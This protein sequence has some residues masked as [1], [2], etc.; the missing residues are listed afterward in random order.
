M[1]G[2]PVVGLDA[3]GLEY[4]VGEEQ[5]GRF[6]VHHEGGVL[7]QRRH[8]ARQ[9]H[10]HLVGENLLSFVV[11]H[12]ATVAVAVETERH[13]GL[14]RQHRVAHGVQHLHVFG[15][16]I[17]A[18]EAVVELA[19]ER[20]H[21]AADRL[22]NARRKSAGGAVAAGGDHFQLALDLRPLGE[23]GDVAVG[24]ILDENV[25]AAAREIELGAEHD[26]LQP[27]H[28]VGPEGERPVGAHLHAG[29]TVVVMR[30]GDHGDAGH[31]QLELR[32]IGH[33]RDRQPDVVHL[34]ARRQQAGDQRQFHRGG[35]A[36]EIVASDDFRL[37]AQL[38][39]QRPQPH[40][41]RLHAHQVDFFFQQPARVVFAKAGRFHQRRRLI[42]VGIGRERGFWRRK[43]QVLEI[44]RG[45]SNS[46]PQRRNRAKRS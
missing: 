35:I 25:T 41:E 46:I 22:Q 43:H 33:R 23:V 27:R 34:A 4:R 1:A 44:K 37:D 3:V 24:E 8:V 10:A 18:R 5:A 7:V 19:I 11:H 39:D 2:L 21:L 6:H 45:Q 17:V 28:L 38:A 31:V 20:H 32:E 9:H 29:P 12:A 26:L 14:I 40:A 16:G 36:A 15:V 42:G 30:G 13:V